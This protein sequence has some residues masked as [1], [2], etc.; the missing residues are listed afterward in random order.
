[1][2]ALA[3]LSLAAV[4]ALALAACQPQDPN[5]DPAAP[6]ADA[7]AASAAAAP[8]A[9]ALDISQP[10]T[11]LGTEPFWSV[12]ITDGTKF[13]LT[14]PDQP[15]LLAEAPGAAISPGGA[16]WV[17]KSADGAQMTV[18]LKPGACGDGMSDR[19]YPISAEVV[20]AGVTL[21]GCAVKASEMPK[22]G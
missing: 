2:R 9:G 19:S 8:A 21:K 18:M 13:K 12:T 1:M 10:I 20:L 22:G 3:H 14:R 4:A 17:A 6:P 11:A 7:P 15:D 16:T 5:G